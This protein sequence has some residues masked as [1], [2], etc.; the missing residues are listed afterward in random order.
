MFLA[1]VRLFISLYVWSHL[2]ACPCKITELVSFH[3]LVRMSKMEAK[4]RV[5]IDQ[6]IEKLVLASGIPSTVEEL[7]KIVKETFAITDDFSLQYL[8][9]E[10]EDYFTLNKTDQVKHKDTIKVVETVPVVLNLLPVGNT[11]F[12]QQETDYDTISTA[13]SMTSS[14]DVSYGSSS[15]QDTIILSPQSATG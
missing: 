13:E 10:F 7:Q 3:V 6:R 5:I 14:T 8:D 11:E 15:S 9:S 1:Y 4:L 2:R 12:A